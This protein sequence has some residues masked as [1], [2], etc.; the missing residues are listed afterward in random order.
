MQFLWTP[1]VTVLCN[2]FEGVKSVIKSVEIARK[3]SK[4]FSSSCVSILID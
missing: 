2:F 4:Q 1:T 3:I